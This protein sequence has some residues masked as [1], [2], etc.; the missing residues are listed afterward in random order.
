MSATRD[1]A[2]VAIDWGTTNLR[3]WPL[4]SHGQPLGRHMSGQGMSTMT[5]DDYPPVLERH[6]S[7]LGVP[8]DTPVV[9]CG[10]AGAR[11][12]WR[13]AAYLEL[14]LALDDLAAGATR[15]SVNNRAIAILPGAAKKQAEAPDVIRSEET[16]LAGLVW[17]GMRD[18]LVCMP[19]THTKWVMLEGGQLIDFQTSMTGEL[20]RLMEQHSILR[21][22]MESGALDIEGRA[23]KTGASEALE[24]PTQVVTKLFSL[25]AA[26]LFGH[27]EPGD[28]RS[29]LSGLLIGLDVAAALQR[30]TVSGTVAVVGGNTMGRAYCSVL[31]LAGH[32]TREYDGEQL[33][34]DGLAMAAR[35]LWPDQFQ[36]AL[37]QEGRATA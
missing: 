15:F 18:G 3:I 2:A 20:F 27:L 35:Q 1:I 37:S 30:Q 12:G 22:S 11:Q 6:L 36:D 16:Q 33:A 14:P 24:N 26:G 32:E 9:V 7:E 5:P 31:A 10:M 8:A 28:I 4:D 19:G 29:R 25:R 21:H 34:L 23:F 13:E 17:S